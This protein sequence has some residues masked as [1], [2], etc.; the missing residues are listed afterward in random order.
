MSWQYNIYSIPNLVQFKNQTPT[1]SLVF[2]RA[3][4]KYYIMKI[5]MK[6]YLMLYFQESPWKKSHNKF[7]QAP[8]IFWYLRVQINHF[9][10]WMFIAVI[11]VISCM[12]YNASFL[13]LKTHLGCMVSHK[14][15]IITHI[16]KYAKYEINQ[17]HKIF[18]DCK[19]IGLVYTTALNSLQIN[20]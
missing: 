11:V 14:A 8:V 9:I 16:G 19:H 4:I 12:K 17:K 15:S 5:F 13:S 6:I 1:I 3:D 2:E 10:F 7:G 20:S 18:I